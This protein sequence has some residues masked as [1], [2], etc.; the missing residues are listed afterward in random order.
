MFRLDPLTKDEQLD[1]DFYASTTFLSER[2]CLKRYLEAEGFLKF[3]KKSFI[4][5]FRSRK[6]SVKILNK[7][8]V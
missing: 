7:N 4:I 8:G 1:A 6:W 3:E 2:A 5:F